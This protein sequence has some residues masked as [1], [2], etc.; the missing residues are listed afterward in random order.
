MLSIIWLKPI[1][2]NRFLKAVNKAKEIYLARSKPHAIDYVKH[3][4]N[5]QRFVVLK[6]E[7]CTIKKIDLQDILYIEGLKDYL[8]I[9]VKGKSKS[10][11][12]RISMKAM[13]E[14]IT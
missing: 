12:P 1:P 7:Y 3:Q 10:Y 4:A 14:K 9:F 13:M 5:K 8:K 2:F 11:L 6:V